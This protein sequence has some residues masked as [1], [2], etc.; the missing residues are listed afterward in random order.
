MG[1]FSGILLA[2]DADGTL[3]GTNGAINPRNAAAIERFIDDGGLFTVA[4]GRTRLAM[5]P[6]LGQFPLNA[7]AVLGNGAFIYDYAADKIAFRRPLDLNYPEVAA[8]GLEI[9]N[10]GLEIHSEDDV[11][12][13]RPNR[14]NHDHFK[15]IGAKA[16]VIDD[17]AIPPRPWLKM[18][19]VG[20]PDALALV[21]ARIKPLCGE[22][23]SLVS[24][25]DVFLEC[26]H[27]DANK[28]AG[29]ATLAEMLQIPT[30]N[31]Y[32]VGDNNNDIPML[33]R[34]HG[35]VP[36]NGSKEAKSHGT[37][38]CHCNDGAVADAISQL[39]INN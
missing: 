6:L 34:F 8:A 37:A 35:F 23:F 24:S 16:I 7:P 15:I 1:K 31:V 18:V 20:E 14:R 13:L 27:K 36:E 12:V 26:L 19:F 28:G 11:W 2:S 22:N 25:V 33:T 30:E 39:I 10:I 5:L 29:V 32:V 9:P 3:V 4:T 17:L 21:K 38:V